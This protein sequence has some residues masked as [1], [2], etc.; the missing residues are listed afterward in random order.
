MVKHES[1]LLRSVLCLSI[2]LT[3]FSLP[4]H[5]KTDEPTELS[6]PKLK[7]GYGPYDYRRASRSQKILVEGAHFFPNVENLRS[8]TTHPNRGYIVIPGSE[9]DYTLRAFPNHPRAL[10][11][12]SRLSLRDGTDKPEGVKAPVECYFQAALKFRPDDS[13]VRVIYGVH[14]AK[15]GHADRALEQLTVAEKISGGSTNLYYNLGLAYFQAERYQEA[16]EAARKAYSLGFPLPGLRDKLKE[17]GEWSDPP[18]APV[19]EEAMQ[20]QPNSSTPQPVEQAF[21]NDPTRRNAAEPKKPAL[22]A[23]EDAAQPVFDALVPKSTEQTFSNDPALRNAAENQRP[24]PPAP[25]GQPIP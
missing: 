8:G 20:P 16:L 25:I 4:V 1:A 5:G 6:C 10:L 13:M 17:V 23:R 11:A 24:V 14:L 18:P 9:I 12:L 15:L 3:A 19:P 7:H 22:P 2:A 21:T